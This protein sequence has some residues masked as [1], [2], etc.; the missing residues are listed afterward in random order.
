M[1]V[2]EAKLYINKAIKEYNPARDGVSDYGELCRHI[3]HIGHAYYKNS[4]HIG[5]GDGKKMCD[6]SARF[7]AQKCDEKTAKAIMDCSGV[8]GHLEYG[9]KLNKAIIAVAEYAEANKEELGYISSRKM[10]K[11]YGLTVKGTSEQINNYAKDE[12]AYDYVKATIENLVKYSAKN[13]EEKATVRFARIGDSKHLV[14]V[15]ENPNNVSMSD[16]E[17]KEISKYTKVFVYDTKNL[18]ISNEVN[19]E[20]LESMKSENFMDAAK[21]SL[22]IRRNNAISEELHKELLA[23]Y[24][25]DVKNQKDLEEQEKKPKLKMLSLDDKPHNLKSDKGFYIGDPTLVLKDEY[26][27]NGI[28]NEKSGRVMPGMY[29]V[30]GVS[31]NDPVSNKYMLVTTCANGQ[32]NGYEIYSGS[33]GVIPLEF[34]DKDKIKALPTESTDIKINNELNVKVDGNVMYVVE[35]NSNEVS[36]IQTSQAINNDKE[37]EKGLEM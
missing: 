4:S 24:S 6:G 35:K 27:D 13:A 32:T 19:I 8:E 12:Q 34:V 36:T 10:F 37:V 9:S 2:Q 28:R 30:G 11:T 18:K 14:V 17:S 7:I 15:N 26:L 1:N 5:V 22:D 20:D 33:I 23:M 25:E 16:E 21:F 31:E 3:A 29:C